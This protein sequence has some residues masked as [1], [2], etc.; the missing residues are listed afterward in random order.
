MFST[1]LMEAVCSIR[2]VGSGIK[3]LDRCCNIIYYDLDEV[4]ESLDSAE[5]VPGLGSDFFFDTDFLSQPIDE[6]VVT[7]DM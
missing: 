7:C 5:N 4:E 3:P 6:E 2:Y 1:L